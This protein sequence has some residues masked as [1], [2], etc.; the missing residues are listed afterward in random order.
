MIAKLLF[1]LKELELFLGTMCK[2]ASDV[3]DKGNDVE[4]EADHDELQ[5]VD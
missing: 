1:Q 4:C 3:L 5:L 2:E